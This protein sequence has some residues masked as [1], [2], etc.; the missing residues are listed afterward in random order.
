MQNRSNTR[1][2]IPSHPIPGESNRTASVTGAK[3]GIDKV[4][5]M[6]QSII[7]AQSSAPVMAGTF[8]APH[9]PQQSSHN[10]GQQQQQ[11]QESQQQYSAEWAAY[12]AAQA[13]AQQQ[14]AAAQPQQQQYAAPHQQQQQHQQQ[15]QYATAPA[16]ADQPAADAYYEQFFRY[17]YYYGED[18]ARAHYGAWAPPV[19]TPNPYGVNPAGTQPA[20]AAEPTPEPVAA[21]APAPQAA[22]APAYTPQAAAP[23]A[24]APRGEVVVDSGRETSRRKVSNLPAWMTK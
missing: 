10:Y 4:Q 8:G 12:R 13:A 5:Q 15:H 16:A 17:A 9:N 18:A 23:H 2:Q 21:A 1:I 7:M 22:A 11:Q 20:P 14:Y 3:E 19:G 6:I 24:P